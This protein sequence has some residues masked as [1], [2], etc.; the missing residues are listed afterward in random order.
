LLAITAAGAAGWFMGRWSPQESASLPGE[1]LVLPDRLFYQRLQKAIGK[2]DS[3]VTISTY[4][5]ITR[6]KSSNLADRLTRDLMKAADRGLRVRVILESDER[7]Q[8]LTSGNQRTGRLLAEGGVEV[9]YDDPRTRS[10]AKVAVI[11]R[12]LTFIGSHNLTDSALKYNRELSLLI[13]SP[14]V[15]EE[16]LAYL[17]DLADLKSPGNR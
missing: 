7:D 3:E 11:D 8:G 9:V 4:L 10:H 14:E 6:G 12:R 15:A 16:I 17:D 13:D 2:A 1:V 5:F